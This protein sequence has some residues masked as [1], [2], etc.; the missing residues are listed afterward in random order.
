MIRQCRRWLAQAAMLLGVLPAAVGAQDA[1]S[2]TVAGRVTDVGNQQPLVGVTVVVVGTTRG[3]LTAQDGTYRIVGVTPGTVQVRAQ[4]IGFAPTTQPAAIT[5]GGT[6]TL[7]FALTAAVTT[8]NEVVI[9]GTGQQARR[10]E[11]GAS[12]ATIDTGRLNLAATPTLSNV[13]Q[14]RTAGVNVQVGGGTT[15]TASRI[16]IRGSN[17]LS[18]NNDPLIIVDGVYLNNSTQGATFGVGGQTTSRFDDIN[19]E[20]IENIEVIKGPSAAALYGTAAANGVIQITTKRGTA[21]RTR[22]NAYA[23]GGAQ[24]DVID[25]PANYSSIG[26]NPTTGARLTGSGCSIDRQAQGQCVP[27]DTLAQANPLENASPLR[28]GNRATYGVNASGGAASATYFLGAELEREQGVYDPNKVG[29]VTVR[30][31]VNG[32]LLPNLRAQVNASYLRSETQLPFNDNTIFGAL[33]Q[34]L[35]GKAFDCNAETVAT[36]PACGRTATARGD[37]SSRGY[38]T[39]NLGPRDFY[40]IRTQQEIS[41]FVGGAT[42]NWEPFSWLTGVGR[43]GLDLVN[44]YDQTL[45]PP[46]Q[47]FFNQS[48]IEGSRFQGRSEIPSYSGNVTFTGTFNPSENVTSATSVGGQYLNEVLRR[49]DASGAV[50]LPGTESLNGASARFTVG[51]FNQQVKT[52]GGYVEQR[53]GFADRV[54]LTTAL[55]ADNN[56][57]F[58]SNFGFVYYPAVNASWVVS[59]EGFF[60]KAEFLDQVRLRGAYGRSGQRPG[61]RQAQTFFDPVSV[62]EA[63]GST[64]Q[65]AITVGGTGNVELRPEVSAEFEGGADVTLFTN[66]VSLEFTGYRK[67]TQDALVNRVLAPSLGATLNQFANLGL[68]ENRGVEAQLNV[69][70]IDRPRFRYEANASITANQNRIIQLGEGISPILFNFSS[71]QQHRGGYPAGGY[72][73]RR[74]LSADDLNGDGLISRVNCPTYGGAANPQLVGGPGCEIVL[75]DSAEYLGSPLPTRE[76]NFNNTFTLFGNVKLTA[77]LNYRG[78]LKQYNSTEEFRCATFQ[79]CRAIQDPSAPLEQQARAIARL[80]GTSAGFIED[81]DLVR[82]REVA[83]TFGLPSRLL[84]RTGATGAS[85]TLAGRNLALW[86]DYTGFDPEVNTLAGAG[87]ANANFGNA[88]FL[89][90]AP[91]RAFTARLNLTF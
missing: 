79:N 87:G 80:M 4:R 50:L 29:R 9:T 6:T 30:S 68:I 67:R 61:F 45:T 41:R 75:S 73:Q 22:W 39:A 57:A 65:P 43:A 23:E 27:R 60:P 81:A 26:S 40:V 7:N 49:T 48:S 31:N 53:F 36:E 14:G 13:L 5:P 11:Q 63:T 64:D 51:E 89:A 72:F 76:I 69:T 33:S 24:R 52:I 10:R 37:S 44:R 74:I 17:S 62:R 16:R 32:Q 38:V 56:S 88:D 1:Q 58:G 35:L 54:F 3:T 18:L 91:I 66:R 8:L 25:Y 77:L 70:P 78:G 82:L 47:L 42:L 21:G 15:G 83:L 19:P 90:Q 55:R 2:G 12:T 85:V 86:T 34:G 59:E 28:T 20:D 46:N 84:S 71:V